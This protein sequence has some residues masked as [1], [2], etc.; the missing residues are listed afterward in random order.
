MYNCNIEEE[1]MF[2]EKKVIKLWQDDYACMIEDT[3]LN[4]EEQHLLCSVLSK[5]FSDGIWDHLNPPLLPMEM[6]HAITA[7]AKSVQVSN[8]LSADG[9]E[10]ASGPCLAGN[11][12]A[13]KLLT[14]HS[15]L[16]APTLHHHLQCGLD[17]GT[18]KCLVCIYR[19]GLHCSIIRL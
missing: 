15:K 17:G 3:E 4:K 16:R 19:L 11:A 9:D 14:V 18:R 12:A 10:H 2:L 1:G 13:E 6:S 5:S 8:S 7:S